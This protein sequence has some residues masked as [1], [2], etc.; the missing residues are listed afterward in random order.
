M[1]HGTAETNHR[2]I[3]GGC[4]MD[5][6]TIIYDYLKIIAGIAG[7]M[8]VT[9]QI[10]SV[11]INPITWLLKTIG[12][13]MNAD[14][15]KDISDLKEQFK[16]FEEQRDK[17]KISQIR[18]EIGEFSVSCQKS[19]KHTIDDFE[20]VF[21]RIREYHELLDKYGLENGKMDIETKYLQ[22]VYSQCLEH[23]E[24]FKGE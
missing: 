17:D 1:I 8:G 4:M 11:P 14:M 16:D 12:N 20:R 21:E 9:L 7:I 6:L 5:E 3:I 15:K 10:S 2:Y 19:E 23:N 13:A 24:F 22:N 18:K